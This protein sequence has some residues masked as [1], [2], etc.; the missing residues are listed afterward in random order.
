MKNK[1]IKLWKV[2]ELDNGKKTRKLTKT[3]TYSNR[4]ELVNVYEQLRKAYNVGI[5]R[6]GKGR[7]QCASNCG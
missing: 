7:C 3:Y 4:E 2:R 1:Q 5:T 6:Y